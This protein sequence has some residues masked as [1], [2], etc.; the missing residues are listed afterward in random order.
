MK[1]NVMEEKEAHIKDP[2][3]DQLKVDEYVKKLHARYMKKHGREI[4][5]LKNHMYE[6]LITNN[7]EGYVY[8]LEKIRKLCLQK[9]LDRD[10]MI[11]LFR[12]SKT[13]VDEII[14]KSM[15]GGELS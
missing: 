12:S 10:V 14:Y 5:R 9:P 15:N 13:S 1:E 11:S 8:G 7:Q 2:V 6:C 3:E 4:T